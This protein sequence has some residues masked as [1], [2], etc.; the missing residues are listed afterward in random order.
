MA[1]LLQGNDYLIL[2]EPYNG[3]DLQS[4]MMLR[5]II[6]RLKEQG[7]TILISSHIFST[8]K[9]ACDEILLLADTRLERTIPKV[10]FDALED[11]M[12][13]RVL[14]KDLDQLLGS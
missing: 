7:K 8:L 1:V 5:A 13:Q 14:L 3:I 9:D 11:E 10:E 12:Q 2:D 6:Q 4:S